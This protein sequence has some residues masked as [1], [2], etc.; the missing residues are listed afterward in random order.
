MD[1]SSGETRRTLIKLSMTL[2]ATLV[3]I[4]VFSSKASATSVTA[5][6]AVQHV[7]NMANSGWGSSNN[8]P[9][10]DGSEWLPYDYG[11][12]QCVDLIAEY[13][14]YLVGWHKGLNANAYATT[15]LPDGWTRQYGDPQP[16]DIVVWDSGSWGHIGVVTS[17]ANGQYYFV[18]T[19][20]DNNYWH[21]GSGYRHN[22][23]AT[24]RGPKSN[25][26]KTVFLRPDFAP[27]TSWLD[28]NGCLDEKVGGD[29]GSYGTC[30][31]YINGQLKAN[32]V[33]DFYSANGLWTVGSS[34]EIK[35]IKATNGHT[36][37]GVYSGSLTGTIGASGT[38]VC[39]KFA[40]THK[41]Q[42][43]ANG[44]TNS[45]TSQT[46]IYG[47]VLTLSTSKPSRNGYKFL[48]WNTKADGSGTEYQPG[49]QYGADADV[50]FYAIWQSLAYTIT[51][52]ANGGTDAPAA[53]TVNN[54]G[55]TTLSSSV[56]IRNGYDFLGWNTS[57]TATS[58]S[59]QA[60]GKY[61]G[62]TATL[63]AI[64]KIKQYTVSFNSNGAGTYD[65]ITVDHG[66]TI[67]NLPTPQRGGYF[68]QGWFL[69]S[70]DKVTAETVVVSDMLLTARWSEP[71]TMLIPSA[72]TAIEEEAF[73]GIAANIIVIPSSVS[74]IGSKA[75]AN[76]NSLYTVIVYSRTLSPAPDAFINCPNL[77][78]CGYADTPIYYYAVAKG[79]PF[80]VIGSTSDWVLDTSLPL[81][82][83]VVS[84]KWTYNQV[85]EETTTST[86]PS[87]AGWTFVSSSWQ[88][89]NEGTWKYAS[90]PSGFDTGHTLYNK[91]NKSALSASE[92]TTTKREVS[93]ASHLTFIY[94]HWTFVD[95]VNDDNHNVLVEDA[96][97]LGVNITGSVYRDFIYFDAF[98]STTDYGTVGPGSSGM[99]DVS[100]LRYAWR[101][102]NSDA[103]Q[104]WWRF[105]VYQQSYMDYEKLFTYKRNG[106][107][108]KESTTEITTGDGIT[109][110]QHWIKYSFE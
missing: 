34:Y 103:S 76:S 108:S 60:G 25:S 97:K 67:S 43:N 86:E 75:F 65:P 26:D 42:F 77:T 52:D 21:D 90:Y 27:S 17:V 18:D 91:Y 83:T 41:V 109:N 31:V 48:S 64:W 45:P 4:V 16:G 47:Y 23:A 32:D 44:G 68:F 101:G 66:K 61:P 56:P 38:S 100:P 78:I 35:D 105:D 85:K 92:T 37:V 11:E 87:L 80:V 93:T 30:D 72:V 9:N 55:E 33:S 81:G 54:G 19:N 96:R 49:S 7:L 20:G 51:Y 102:I 15:G 3:A 8:V 98:E 28:V 29:L 39:L 5:A 79:I 40:T 69:S 13:W 95:S 104:W 46:K 58:A 53:Q 6:Q 1:H 70:D 74:S 59:Y 88:K 57:R 82:A 36:Y 12:P 14:D 22:T 106:T 62:G 89:T 24:L 10:Y 107:E 63:Y 110:V 2:I 84:E 73:E 94:W 50:T 71:T 99:I